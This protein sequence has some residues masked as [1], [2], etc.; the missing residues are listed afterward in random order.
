MTRALLA[1]LLLAAAGCRSTTDPSDQVPLLTALPRALSTGEQAAIAANNGFA[2]RLANALVAAQPAENVF[3]SPLSVSFALGMVLNGAQGDT[4]D[5]M[6]TTLGFGALP[7]AEINESYRTLIALLLGLDSRVEYTIAN[8]L[9]AHQGFPIKQAFLDDARRFFD[10]EAR[11]IDFGASSAVSTINGWV[12]DKTRGK[13][14]TIIEQIDSNE[15]LF[16]INAIY[17]KGLWR[18]QFKK[19]ETAPGTFHRAGGGTQTVPFMHRLVKTPYRQGANFQAVDLWYGAGA[20]TMTV[21]VPAA[22]VSI[23]QVIRGLDRTGWDALTGGLQPLDVDLFLPKL[24]LEYKRS[25]KDDLGAL[26]MNLAFDAGRAN[27]RGIAEDDLYLTRVDHK[28]FVD[29]NEEGTEAAAVTN[30]G[31]G[32]TSLPQQVTLRV[33]RPFLVVLRERLSGTITFLGRIN[34]IPTG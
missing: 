23:D 4:R 28:T 24:R 22:G 6:A 29:I 27:F 33:D 34:S 32:V 1:L 12:N 9:W 2:F 7:Q 18:D 5:S 13:I 11:A 31:V 15:I 26:G 10:A 14:P 20:H 17:F 25:L 30:V 3:V 21:V 16:A 19:A 8:S